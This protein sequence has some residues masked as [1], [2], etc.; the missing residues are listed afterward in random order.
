M[1]KQYL[2]DDELSK[3]PQIMF[4]MSVNSGAF[5]PPS[6]PGSPSKWSYAMS[7]CAQ[8]TWTEQVDD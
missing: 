6:K 8:K 1:Q 4:R 5:L 2:S 7:F 3:Q